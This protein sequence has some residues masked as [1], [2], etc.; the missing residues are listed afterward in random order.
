MADYQDKEL[1][2]PCPSKV[3]PQALIEWYH[4]NCKE[5]PKGRL[6]IDTEANIFCNKCEKKTFIAKWS[7]NCGSEEH[8]KYHKGK[9]LNWERS[10]L[11]TCLGLVI[12]S[13]VESGDMDTIGF[14]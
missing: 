4:S 12:Q 10:A 7:F 5:E 9:F 11:G 1:T 3:C 6:M 2:F 13:C 8:K 14:L